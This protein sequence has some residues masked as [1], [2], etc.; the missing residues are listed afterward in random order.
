MEWAI[1]LVDNAKRSHDAHAAPSENFSPYFT[2]YLSTHG[3]YAGTNPHNCF[4]GNGARLYTDIGD[5][6]E[7]ATPEDDSIVGT[8]ANEI[9]GERIVR[10]ALDS[11]PPQIENG[12]GPRTYI[13]NKRV[14][15]DDG[16]TWGYHENYLSPAAYIKIDEACLALLGVHLATRT[17]F[18]GAGSVSDRGTFV[19]SQKAHRLTSDYLSGTTGAKPV[20]NLR[21][22]PHADQ[23]AWRRV[24]VTCGDPNMSPWATC[25]KLGTTSLVLRLI[26]HGI[27]LPH[28]RF[29]DSLHQVAAEVAHDTAVQRLYP[30]KWGR[31]LG[32]TAIQRELQ[33]AAHRL[34]NEI[35]LPDEE[36]W[37]LA[38]WDKACADLQQNPRL[39]IN[40]ADW[41][42]KQSVLQRQAA[43]RGAAWTTPIMQGIDRQW[44]T[45]DRGGFGQK[46]RE[47]AWAD[48]MPPAD[49]IKQRMDSPPATTR[50]AIRSA[51]ISHFAQDDSA[52]VDWAL[53]RR[54]NTQTI[55]LTDPYATRH[56]AV[57]ELIRRTAA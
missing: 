19:L 51:F 18:T 27:T 8:L 7:Y 2:H 54:G 41:A 26:E 23:Q 22:E 4:L 40:R 53:L 35:I 13:L 20:V 16:E 17:I 11:H 10:A 6:K 55:R 57:D 36:L 5:H 56:P 33:S 3:V 49:L 30:L 12:P 44:D 28:L 25:M 39:L 48:W 46:L 37:A 45:I 15:D 14:I 43:K 34:A 50:A 24:H 42:A 32:A 9:A 38:E 29:R 1:T 47:T 31:A 21:I 52:M